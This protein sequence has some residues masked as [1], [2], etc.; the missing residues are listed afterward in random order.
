MAEF[1]CPITKRKKLSTKILRLTYVARGIAWVF[2]AENGCRRF[3]TQ[4]TWREVIALGI[5][6]KDRRAEIQRLLTAA[7]KSSCWLYRKRANQSWKPS[8]N[9]HWFGQSLLTTDDGRT[10]LTSLLIQQL[11]NCKRYKMK[12]YAF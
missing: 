6:G 5:K 9:G 3:E 1:T 11:L 4:P 10:W 2:R 7:E 12:Q 8:T